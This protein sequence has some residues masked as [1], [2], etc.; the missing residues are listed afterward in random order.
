VEQGFLPRRAQEAGKYGSA[1]AAPQG[2]TPCARPAAVA[3][4]SKCGFCDTGRVNAR[5]PNLPHLSATPRAAGA[6][7]R[8]LVGATAL[9][10]P[11]R[12][13]ERPTAP[14]LPDA[15]L[16]AIGVEGAQ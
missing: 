2:Q 14:M 12:I 7:A 8:P 5:P 3:V 1:G 10:G 13:W 9:P 6:W 16:R 15:P 11:E 4:P